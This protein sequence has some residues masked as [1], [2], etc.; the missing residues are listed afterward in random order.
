MG[1]IDSSEFAGFCSC[2]L[3]STA[4]LERF[5]SV[6]CYSHKEIGMICCVYGVGIV[7]NTVQF[8]SMPLYF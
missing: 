1:W 4:T 8:I 2:W 7:L 5:G 6:Y 3:K